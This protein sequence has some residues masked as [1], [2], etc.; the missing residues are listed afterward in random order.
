MPGTWISL[1]NKPS[2]NAGH[3]LL[4]T[5]GT[6][7][8]QEA[9][10]SN[11]HSLI[12]DSTG[13]YVNGRWSQLASSV[14]SSGSTSVTYAPTFY[15]SAL[16]ADGTVFFA[17][18]EDDGGNS[19]SCTCALYDPTV[20][21]GGKW[22]LLP[23]PTLSSGKFWIADAPCCVLP[24]GRV[25]LGATA[26]TESPFQPGTATA[27]FDPKA[28]AQN[29]NQSPW[30][31]GPDNPGT[32]WEQ[33]WTLLPDGTVL[34]PS[35]PIAPSVY[36]FLID[37]SG[38][39][40]VPAGS[41]LQSVIIDTET[42]P[43]LLLLDGTVLCFGATPHNALYTAPAHPADAGTWSSAPDFP[44][45]S[46][47]NSY[48][49]SDA[50]VVLL[51]NGKAFCPVGVLRSSG[52]S[53]PPAQFVEFTPAQ[54]SAGSFQTVDNPPCEQRPAGETA[55][56]AMAHRN[57]GNGA[58]GDLEVYLCGY[59]FA[60]DPTK[61]VQSITLP[62]NRNVIVMSMALVAANGQATNVSLASVANV[63]GACPD[64]ASFSGGGLDGDGFA[65]SSNLL[66][67]SQTYSGTTMSLGTNGVSGATVSLPSGSY[68]TLK[69]L[70]TA[71]NGT[72]SAQPFTVNYKDGSSTQH[73]QTLSDWAFGYETEAFSLLLLPTG[74]V[75]ATVGSTD[76]A[77]YR[78]DANP[79]PPASAAPLITN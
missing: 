55:V 64:G 77:I 25:L 57:G 74:E 19:N 3:M 52:H 76:V 26:I 39:R 51:P 40:W 73:K 15:A 60:L 53:G 70:A 65:Y 24:D 48:S 78:P 42:G 62:A 22:T 21:N 12:P 43:S 50:P 4:L 61:T 37:A 47:G 71:V 32:N 63:T 5:D 16:L 9:G 10:S 67:T 20:A 72:Q 17:G 56:V 2:F 79:A 54:G 49:M 38:P 58:S 68:A 45:D 30:T 44:T 66:G 27:I 46:S 36:K 69:I 34:A 11:W 29:P 1:A 6:V 7:M 18:G 75:M 59:S 28:F 35:I 23:S 14:M 8:V 31:A 33:T 41:P 13:S